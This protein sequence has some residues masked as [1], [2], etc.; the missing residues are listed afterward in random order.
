[1][2][3]IALHRNGSPSIKCHPW[4]FLQGCL[5]TNH[6]FP[7]NWK[8]PGIESLSWNSS[9]NLTFHKRL[10]NWQ[11]VCGWLFEWLSELG[12]KCVR[13]LLA[14]CTIILMIILRKSGSCQC[15]SLGE[16]LYFNWEPLS[17]VGENLFHHLCVM[18]PQWARPVKEKEAVLTLPSRQR[19]GLY[20]LQ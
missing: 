14:L 16:V 17:L 8:C 6:C 20:L 12:S 15:Y 2:N 18:K 5:G 19:Y 1:M 7:L 13:A 9:L 4:P 10:D 11:F 3:E